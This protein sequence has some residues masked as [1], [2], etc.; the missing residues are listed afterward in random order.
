MAG[1]NFF[2]RLSHELL[3]ATNHISTRFE[4]GLSALLGDDEAATGGAKN[5]IFENERPLADFEDLDLDDMDDEEVERI[6]QQMMDHSP[7]EG[8]ADNV[9]ADI[10]SRQVSYFTA[11]SCL[12]DISIC[13]IQRNFVLL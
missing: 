3:E 6:L 4:E 12:F 2:H 11:P 7:L 5:G 10:V 13:F 8:I 1:E 9:L